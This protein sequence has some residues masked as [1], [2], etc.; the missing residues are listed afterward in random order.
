MS[1]IQF[2][3]FASSNN[4]LKNELEPSNSF[5]NDLPPEVSK[6]QT[7]LDI[8]NQKDSKNESKPEKHIVKDQIPQRKR[9]KVIILNPKQQANSKHADIA[10]NSKAVKAM[11]MEKTTVARKWDTLSS[12]F[13]SPLSEFSLM[14]S[15]NYP[16]PLL[17]SLPCSF[18]FQYF[19]ELIQCTYLKVCPCWC[20]KYCFVQH[21]CDIFLAK[22][23]LIFAVYN[24]YAKCRSLLSWGL[25]R[26]RAQ[27][28][29]SIG[30]YSHHP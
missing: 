26:K 8:I 11:H 30:R 27:C 22:L 1:N 21:R 12:L 9:Q 2:N 14:S 25:N 19:T 28:P 6:F 23:V 7:I 20:P 17:P 15:L 13:D 5:F 3:E 10:K 24:E 29:H 18:L 4:S 16:S